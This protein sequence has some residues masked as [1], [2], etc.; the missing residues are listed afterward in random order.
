MGDGHAP[1]HLAQLLVHEDQIEAIRVGRPRSGQIGT[2]LASKCDKKLSA[3]IKTQT[4]VLE[5]TQADFVDPKQVIC[6][7]SAELKPGAGIL[8][9]CPRCCPCKDCPIRLAAP[10]GSSGPAIPS[11]VAPAASAT[12]RPGARHPDLR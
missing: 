10:K 4:D 11:P 1:D 6:R 12:I 9:Q 5:V 8:V 7:G 3:T 2:P